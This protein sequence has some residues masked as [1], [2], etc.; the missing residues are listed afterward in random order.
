MFSF[1][2]PPGQEVL[3]TFAAVTPVWLKKNKKKSDRP[4][5]TQLSSEWNWSRRHRRHLGRRLQGRVDVGPEGLEL[6]EGP[7]RT[8]GAGEGGQVTDGNRSALRSQLRMRGGTHTHTHTYTCIYLCED[9]PELLSRTIAPNLN[10]V[11]ITL[12]TSPDPQT[13]AQNR[14]DH[15]KCPHFARGMRI[16]PLNL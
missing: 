4:L 10:A 11:L 8:G 14:Q 12:K 9:I 13:H 1:R 3:L 5:N 6:R 7:M 15:T 16:L 2:F